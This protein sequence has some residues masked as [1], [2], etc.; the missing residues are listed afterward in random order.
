MMYDRRKHDVRVEVE[1]RKYH[2]IKANAIVSRLYFRLT[3][4]GIIAG[5]VNL[6]TEINK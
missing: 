3:L 6:L 5:W 4:L 1:R 2:R